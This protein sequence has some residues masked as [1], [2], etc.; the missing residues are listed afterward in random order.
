MDSLS[1]DTT[2]NITGGG[3]SMFPVVEYSNSADFSNFATLGSFTV[4]G[5]NTTWY[6]EVA[7]DAPI[8]DGTGTYYFRLYNSTN[9]SGSYSWNLDNVSLNGFVIAPTPE[10]VS[11]SVLVLAA[12]ALM[13][14]R[15]GAASHDRE[16]CG[17]R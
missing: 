4:N 3:G 10:P 16:E 5:P 9:A 12:A 14:R 11:L 13:L 15:R 17:V 1:F 8:T 2:T 7:G 6:T